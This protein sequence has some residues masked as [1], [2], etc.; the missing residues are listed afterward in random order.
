ML[1]LTGMVLNVFRTKHGKN[2]AGEEF[3]GDDKVQLLSDVPAE[4]GTV[5]KELIDLKVKDVSVFERHLNEFCAIPV[6]AFA[7]GKGNII[8]FMTGQPEFSRP[9]SAENSV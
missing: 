4:D 2:K 1:Q 8:F 3:G 9:K 6:G 5:K 7:P